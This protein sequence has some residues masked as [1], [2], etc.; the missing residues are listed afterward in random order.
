MSTSSNDDR[1]W[2]YDA[3]NDNSDGSDEDLELP[4]KKKNLAEARKKQVER[5]V[6][7]FTPARRKIPVSCKSR[8]SARMIAAVEESEDISIEE[9]WRVTLRRLSPDFFTSEEGKL[10]CRSAGKT[11]YKAIPLS[12][13]NNEDV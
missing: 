10:N 6:A 13:K 7:R 3:Q 1:E 11:G 8:K 9:N 4:L 12:E 2:K 5:T